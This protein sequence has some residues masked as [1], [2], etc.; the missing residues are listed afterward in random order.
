MQEKYESF[1]RTDDS[2]DRSIVAKIVVANIWRRELSIV[3]LAEILRLMRA[4]LAVDYSRSR[5]TLVEIYQRSQV[6]KY[7]RLGIFLPLTK[8]AGNPRH[9]FS[10]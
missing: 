8:Y 4:I 1:S 3:Y 6:F 7:D 2:T 9:N 5:S 10:A